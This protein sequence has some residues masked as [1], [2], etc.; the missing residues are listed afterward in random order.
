MTVLL[1][2]LTAHNLRLSVQVMTNALFMSLILIH[3]NYTLSRIMMG[4]F[5]RGVKIKLKTPT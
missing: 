5:L 1:G 4:L 2:H 3:G